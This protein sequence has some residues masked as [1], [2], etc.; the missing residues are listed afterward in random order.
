MAGKG[1]RDGKETRRAV[2]STL[3]SDWLA[4]DE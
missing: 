4:A 1:G 2:N 3:H